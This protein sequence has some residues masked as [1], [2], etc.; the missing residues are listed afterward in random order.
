MNPLH[1]YTDRYRV[2]DLWWRKRCGRWEVNVNAQLDRDWGDEPVTMTFLYD[3]YDEAAAAVEDI[4]RMSD[5][6]IR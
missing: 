5:E 2:I 6:R 1:T 4:H 3:D